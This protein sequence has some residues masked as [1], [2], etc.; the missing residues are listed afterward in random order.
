MHYLAYVDRF[1]EMTDAVLDRKKKKKANE[2]ALAD[3]ARVYH[4]S[5]ETF[6]TVIRN[7]Y[8]SYTHDYSF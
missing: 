7:G 3:R 2:S 1:F 8:D 4:R 6:L 5:Y